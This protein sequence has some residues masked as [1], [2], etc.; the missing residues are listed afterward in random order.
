MDKDYINLHK[1]INKKRT[2]TGR[3]SMCETTTKPTEFANLSQEYLSDERDWIEVCHACHGWLDTKIT[4]AWNQRKLVM[5]REKEMIERLKTERAGLEKELWREN[6][7]KRVPTRYG[8]LVELRG[9]VIS[10]K[11]AA[12]RLGL[13]QSALSAHK[14]EGTVPVPDFKFLG[15]GLYDTLTG[16]KISADS[17]LPAGYKFV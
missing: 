14:K 3:C 17:Q 10:A 16:K 9:E 12:F 1:K 11:E 15:K 7:H 5:Q 6:Q 2:K 4:F 8:F 13:S